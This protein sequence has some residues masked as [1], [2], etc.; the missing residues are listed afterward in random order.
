MEKTHDDISRQLNL[1]I[2]LPQKDYM[3]LAQKK[4]CGDYA[5]NSSE[6][7]KEY[8]T[9]AKMTK[10]HR[11]GKIDAK[12]QHKSDKVPLTELSKSSVCKC[13]NK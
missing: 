5:R 3:D 9:Q 1:N 8:C 11:M 4:Q 7:G 2:T 13:R 10:S 6:L 12:K